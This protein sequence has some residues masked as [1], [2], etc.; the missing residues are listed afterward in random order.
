MPEHLSFREIIICITLRKE[1]EAHLSSKS[2]RLE[3]HSN[4]IFTWGLVWESAF[5]KEPC[6]YMSCI[7]HVIGFHLFLFLCLARIEHL[8]SEHVYLHQHITPNPFRYLPGQTSRKNIYTDLG[9]SD[10]F[11]WK[12]SINRLRR[13][14][15]HLDAMRTHITNVSPRCSSQPFAAPSSG[16]PIA[17]TQA[18]A[19]T[20]RSLSS[21]PKY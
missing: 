9:V 21:S 1:S 3:D 18:S 8:A 14:Y 5:L 20:S 7:I 17:W 11:L 13:P 4:N 6:F 19:K 16:V 10:F 15:N 2:C 12:L